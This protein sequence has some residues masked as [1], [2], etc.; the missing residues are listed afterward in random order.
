MVQDIAERAERRRDLKGQLGNL[1]G[2]VQSEVIFEHISPGRE[3]V[4]VYSTQNGEPIPVPAYMIDPVMA[5]TLP[6][7]KPM[8]VAKKE[9]APEFILGTVKCFL[10]PESPERAILG[11]IG[12]SGKTCPAAHLASPHSK[13]VHGEKR[14]K[15][16]WAAYQEFVK[17]E[18][19]AA[20]EARQEKMLQA[21]LGS[22]SK[23]VPS[24]GAPV[25][26]PRPEEEDKNPT[27]NSCGE[28]IEGALAA[29][30]CK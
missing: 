23:A 8:F 22:A 25:E 27:C 20:T 3:P 1:G 9:D 5:K 16:E 26:A 29:H 21:A 4:T 24:Q 18:K 7:G 12:L 11:Q 30:Q 14:H 6:G 28:A 13:R 17:E 2:L 10:H 15:Q 19:E